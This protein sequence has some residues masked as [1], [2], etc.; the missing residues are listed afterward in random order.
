MRNPS[1]LL[2]ILIP[3]CGILNTDPYCGISTQIPILVT[4]N[5]DPHDGQ[6]RNNSPVTAPEPGPIAQA[7]HTEGQV[8]QSMAHARHH[9]R[10]TEVCTFS[11][12]RTH[13]TT[14]TTVLPLLLVLLLLLLLPTK[15]KMYSLSYGVTVEPELRLFET[16]APEAEVCWCFFKNWTKPT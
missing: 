8:E 2:L 6:F 9:L 15:C 14:T 12:V 16:G 5:V 1:S 10:P 11:S 4:Y 3:Q 7:S 13:A